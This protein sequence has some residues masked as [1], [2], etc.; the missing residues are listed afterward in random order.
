MKNNASQT[1]I[2]DFIEAIKLDQI[3]IRFFLSYKISRFGWSKWKVKCISFQI[4]AMLVEL[5]VTDPI[6][7]VVELAELVGL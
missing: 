1:Y 5:E 4:F 3:Y 7:A 2:R 6:F